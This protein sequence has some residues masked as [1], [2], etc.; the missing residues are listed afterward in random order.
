MFRNATSWKPLV[1]AQA[2]SGADVVS[3]GL[4]LGENGADRAEHFFGGNPGGVGL[5]ANDYGTA[6]LLRRAVLDDVTNAWPASGDPDWTLLAGLSAGE[7]EW[8]RSRC[9]S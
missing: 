8:C 5:L 6:A 2:A 9:H 7:L 3:C 4:Y 1:R